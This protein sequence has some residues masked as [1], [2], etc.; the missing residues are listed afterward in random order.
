MLLMLR[1]QTPSQGKG[2]LSRLETRQETELVNGSNFDL[3]SKKKGGG[4]HSSS[5]R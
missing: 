1:H 2:S 4:I 5:Q 3:G